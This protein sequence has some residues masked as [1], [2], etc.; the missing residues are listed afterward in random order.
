MRNPATAEKMQTKPK[1]VINPDEIQAAIFDM[2]GVITDTA[3]IHANSWKKM[4]DEYLSEYYTQQ[5]KAFKPFDINNDYYRFIDGKP[6]FDGVKSFLQSREIILPMGEPGDTGQDSVYGLGNRKNQYFLKLLQK[7]K[8]RVYNSTLDLVRSMKEKGM[9]AAVISASRNA[10]AILEAV[11]ILVLFDAK[12][13]GVDSAKLGLKGK[14]EPDIF[15]EAAAR[16]KSEPEHTVI[17][18]DSLSGVEAGKRGKFKLVVGVDRVGQEKNLKKSGAGIVV[19]DL[20]EIEISQQPRGVE[21]KA[22]I[23][24]LPSALDNKDEIFRK[25]KSGTPVVSLDYDGT[26][27]P[28]VEN[29]AKATLD[30]NLRRIIRRLAEQWT[31]AI[32]SGRDLADVRSMVRIGDIIYS[33]SHGFD[34]AGP[35][36]S[37]RTQGNGERFLPALDRAESELRVAVSKIPKAKVERKRFAIAV[38]YRE[39]REQD[40]SSLDKIVEE[41]FRH[42]TDLRLTTGKKIW[43]FVPDIDWDKGRALLALYDNLF[44]DRSKLV[45][46]FIGDDITDENAFRAIGTKGIN[47]VVGEEDRE[48]EANFRLKNPGE[49]KVFL[50]SMASFAEKE[51]TKGIWT[52]AYEGF[53]PGQEKLREAL[54]TTGNGYFAS[55][56]AAPEAQASE[57]HYPGTYIAGIYNRL[58]TKLSGQQLENESLVNAPNWLSFTF[59]IEEEDWFD[60]GKVEITAYHQELDMRNGILMRSISFKD[61]AGR[62]TKLFQRRFV[63]QDDPHLAGLETTLEAENW[64]GNISFLSALDGRVLNNGI[65]RYSQLNNKNL[66]PVETREIERDTVL[67]KVITNQS[68]IEIC[69]AARTRVFRKQEKQ[70]VDFNLKQESGYIGH[71]F[72]LVIKQGETLTI[73]KVVALFTSRDNAISECGMAAADKINRTDGLK[74]LLEAHSIQWDHLWRRCRISID[75]DERTAMI[76]HLHVFHLLQTVSISSIDLDTGVPARGLHGEAYRGHVFWDELFIFPFLNFRIPDITRSLMMYRY[77]R[78]NEARWNARKNGQKGALFPWQSGSNGREESPAIHLNPRSGRWI[79]DNSSLQRHINIAIAYNVWLYYQVT[80]DLDFLSYYGTEMLIELARFWAGLTSYNSSLERYEICGVMGP[81]EYHDGYPDAE[82]PGM[83]TN[84]YTNIMAVWTI[85]RAMDAVKLLPENRRE[86]LLEDLDLRPEELSKWDEVSHRMR[87]VFH[88]ND[89]ISQFEGYDRLKEF[90]WEGY[91]KKYGSIERLDRILEL[92]GDSPN[93]YK[94]S[95]QADVLMLFYL[96]SADELSALFKRLDYP[97]S[98][99]SIPKNIEYYLQRTSHGSTLSR[100]VHSWVVARSRRELSWSL[101]KHA[102][103]SDI[104]DIQGG[105]TQEG[106]HLG[107]MAGS[108][109]LIQRCYTGIEPRDNKLWLNPNIPDELKN[110]QFDILYRRQWINLRIS[111][112]HLIIYSRNSQAAPIS[113]MVK[114]EPVELKAGSSLTF[115]LD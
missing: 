94:L 28:I 23:P 31:V 103:E 113:L 82:K 17:F 69:Q 112:S 6:R 115:E 33:G 67:L 43:E 81:D 4:F 99:A 47:I 91:R 71:E 68:R 40:I 5:K 73:E 7:E 72:N 85:C 59:K 101:F 37:Y 14:P 78:L 24:D 76:L 9:K 20:S 109:D 106:I 90:D 19:H 21:S 93:N 13:D 96:L 41:T 52:L 11:D 15:L 70:A 65:P 54:C 39:G 29:P 89:I 80:G 63:S 66:D 12:V 32:V 34:I 46:V 35:G 22:R 38:H 53:D 61:K 16:I 111:S 10:E 27:T 18:E 74:K 49:V 84:S 48:T 114:G 45:P 87:V 97:F 2:D 42:L 57:T 26:L 1:L 83:D 56:G 62:R 25:L 50:E 105:T 107:A 110:V 86:I 36:E 44:I 92:E 55:R 64:S 95:K 108:V 75:D 8:I 77:R 98:T 58:K 88:D 51:V 102:L 79:P 104:S 60:L 100:I 3:L 30:E